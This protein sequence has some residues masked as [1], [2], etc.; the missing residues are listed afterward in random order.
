MYPTPEPH[1]RLETIDGQVVERRLKDL[2]Q[3]LR[4]DQGGY[5]THDGW[6]FCKDTGM[7]YV[8]FIPPSL[9]RGRHPNERRR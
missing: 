4:D 9:L 5:I 6:Y 7:N 3:D 1:I 8:T 2:S